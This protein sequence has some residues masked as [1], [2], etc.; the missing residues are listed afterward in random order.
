MMPML[1]KV[2]FACLL[3]AVSF[4]SALAACSPDP[5]PSGSADLGPSGSV[6]VTPSSGAFASL[7]TQAGAAD[8]ILASCIP[9]FTDDRRDWCDGEQ[10]RET[11]TELTA[12]LKNDIN[13]R[14]DPARFTEV[15]TAITD[16]ERSAGLVMRQCERPS[17]TRF[18]CTEAFDTMMSDW[19]RLKATANWR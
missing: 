12:A 4:V 10:I 9:R 6:A 3:G 8:V 16:L 18:E 14:P 7:T 19:R 13:S 2:R 15:S 1:N 17:G 11:I 5:G